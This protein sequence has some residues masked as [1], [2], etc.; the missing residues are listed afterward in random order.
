MI[1]YVL[2]GVLCIY[3]ILLWWWQIKV[4]EGRAMKNPDG[5]FDDWR[6]QKTHYGMALADVV[7]AC[8]LAIVGTILVFV[9]SRWGVF[10]MALEGY[11]LL[12]VNLATTA[13]SL[14]FMKPRLNFVWFMTFPFGSLWGLLY[15]I[16]T[17]VHFQPVFCQ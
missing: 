15:L 10:I 14:R 13:T 7:L 6:E 2:T 5:S 17:V 12:W 16:W 4:L 8:P 1:L 3:F 9:G 11:F